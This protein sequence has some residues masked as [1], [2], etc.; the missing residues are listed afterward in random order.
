M[1]D[2]TSSPTYLPDSLLTEVEAARF[3]RCSPRTLARERAA[4]EIDFFQRKAGRGSQVLYRLRHLQEYLERNTRRVGQPV[5]TTRSS[6]A[7]HARKT[8]R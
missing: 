5:P 8:R 1:P 6:A 7:R 4:G 2:E 3:L